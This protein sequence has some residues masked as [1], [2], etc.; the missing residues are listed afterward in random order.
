MKK[1]FLLLLLAVCALSCDVEDETVDITVMPEATT[2]GAD[3]FGCLIDG[4]VY[5]GGRHT[6]VDW[7]ED[8]PG[9]RSIDFQYSEKQEKMYVGVKVKSDTFIQFI[10]LSPKNGQESSYVD[11]QF[12]GEEMEDGKAFITRF[13]T[14]KKIISGTFGGGSISNGRFD[15]HYTTY[16]EYEEPTQDQ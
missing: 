5:V 4:W 6:T 10:L 12:D 16:K 1:I 7:R 9:T 14:K 11:A 15:I 13:D 8:I 3:T 2:M